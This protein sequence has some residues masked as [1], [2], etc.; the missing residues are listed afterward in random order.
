MKNA[1]LSTTTLLAAA[2]L[3][4]VAAWKLASSGQIPSKPTP[5]YLA[6]AVSLL[7]ATIA[8]SRSREGDSSGGMGSISSSR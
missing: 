6:F 7:M 5:Y 1:L 2:A 4:G 8:G 3:S